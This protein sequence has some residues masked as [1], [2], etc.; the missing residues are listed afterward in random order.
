MSEFKFHTL[1]SAPEAAKPLL[2]AVKEKMGFVPNLYLGLA[3]APAALEAYLTLSDII[4][5]TSFSAQ[6]QQILMLA[7]SVENA[8]LY[9]VAAHSS[10]ARM[11]K[12]DKAV[13]E[14]I[15]SDQVI[16]DP[17]LEALRKF[18]QC[19]VVERGFVGSELE[20]FLSAGYTRS[21]VLEVIMVVAMKTLSNY[22]NH[23]L[24]TPVDEILARMTWEGRSS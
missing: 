10:G 13:I 22:A 19:V 1:E 12:V 7:V 23:L 21:Q 5:R 9:C 3:D 18:A 6:E 17:N 4:T 15:R 16:E 8:C 20:S 2:H 11:F 24:E 14:A